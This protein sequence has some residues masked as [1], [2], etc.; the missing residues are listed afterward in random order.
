MLHNDQL[1]YNK[2]IKRGGRKKKIIYIKDFSFI[3]NIKV[4]IIRTNYNLQ[5]YKN[6]YIYIKSYNITL[7]L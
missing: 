1:C 6:I 3:L 4:N 2:F 5:Q 7:N